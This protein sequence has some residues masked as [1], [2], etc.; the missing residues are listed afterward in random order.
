MCKYRE[1][2]ISIFGTSNQLSDYQSHQIKLCIYKHRSL[3]T[4]T[5]YFSKVELPQN[6]IYSKYFHVNE[7]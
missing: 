3:T 5:Y 1:C 4:H 2:I 7:K 6:A